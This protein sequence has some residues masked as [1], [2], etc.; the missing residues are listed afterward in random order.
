MNSN[1]HA[2]YSVPLS[3]ALIVIILSCIFAGTVVWRSRWFDNS[4]KPEEAQFLTN[5]LRFAGTWYQDGVLVSRFGCYTIPSSVE[6][7]VDDRPPYCGYPPGAAVPLYA[8][9]KLIGHRPTLSM[10]MAHNLLNHLAVSIM[11]SLTAFVLLLQLKCS[12]A[13]AVFWSLVPGLIELLAPSP[14]FQFQMRYVPDHAVILPF[15]L[16]VLLEFLRDSTRTARSRRVLEAA[17][18]AVGFIGILTD[19][20]FGLV[21]ACVYAKRLLFGELGKHTGTFAFRS[22]CFWSPIATGVL[23]FLIQLVLLGEQGNLADKM[24][25]WSSL[26]EKSFPLL[27][28]Y[29]WRVHM[30]NG[31]GRLGIGMIG[32]SC[33][34]MLTGLAVALFFKVRRVPVP[35]GLSKPLTLG[36]LLTFPC[37]LHALLLPVHAAFPFHTFAALKFSVPLGMVPFLVIPLIV[38]F[39]SRSEWVLDL[40]VPFVPIG[41]LAL[42]ASYAAVESPRT[43]ALFA[44]ER[45]DTLARS[46]AEFVGANTSWSDVVFTWDPELAIDTNSNHMA[47]SM[48][49]A[50]SIASLQQ[51]ADV[52]SGVTNEYVVNILSREHAPPLG[53]NCDLLAALTFERISKDGFT[54]GRIRKGSFLEACTRAN[55]A[56]SSSRS[57][58]HRS[59]SG[60]YSA[61]FVRRL[62]LLTTD[63]DEM[64]KEMDGNASG[65]HAAE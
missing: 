8:M 16:F 22:L 20:L 63:I 31:Y 19:Y 5:V 30:V 4:G 46:V 37:I 61:D 10:L 28:N 40:R 59:T 3:I 26:S 62:G 45:E 35:Q 15:V 57:K 33:A 29:F 14:M 56:F 9:A 55:V 51:M 6:L 39:L 43:G 48:K 52:V 49:A 58:E 12:R 41:M 64:V 18:V 25:L 2:R 38:I 7:T 53:N 34:A 17:Q 13:V 44:R 24:N 36:C 42:A 65:D 27:N 11:L 60:T 47:F 1:S 32:L 54:L 23:A 50:H 21:A